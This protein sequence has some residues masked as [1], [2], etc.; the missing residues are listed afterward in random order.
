MQFSDKDILEHVRLRVF[1]RCVSFEII[2]STCV[3]ERLRGGSAK[4]LTFSGHKLEKSENQSVLPS[5]VRGKRCS[6]SGVFFA[7]NSRETFPDSM[8]R[9]SH[10]RL[11]EEPEGRRLP[12]VHTC[13]E[14]K[15]KRFPPQ[16]KAQAG[17]G[18]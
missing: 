11:A 13:A 4:S 6:V 2:T 10:V 15:V 16:I 8:S 12:T 3:C 7:V 9:A 17:P 18:V 1:Y 14:K 5:V